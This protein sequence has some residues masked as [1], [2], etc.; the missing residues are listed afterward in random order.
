MEEV[1]DL[2]EGFERDGISEWHDD[3]WCFS[4]DLVLG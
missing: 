1:G 3:D 2:T 4:D